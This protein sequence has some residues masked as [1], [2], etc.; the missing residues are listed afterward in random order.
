[1][2]HK[3]GVHLANGPADHRTHIRLVGDGC[4]T[5]LHTEAHLLPT[6]RELAPNSLI[7]IRHYL[8][9]WYTTDIPQYARECAERYIQHKRFTKHLTWANEQNLADESAGVIGAKPDRRITRT[10]YITIHNWNNKFITAFLSHPG[11]EDAILHYP[12]F[13]PG[14]SD[15]NDD[16]GFV[17]LEIC[18]PSIERCAILDRH[19]YPRLDSFVSNEWHGAGRL[20]HT[21]TKFPSKPIFISECGNFTVTDPRSPEHYISMGKFWEQ[22]P[23]VLGWTY[24]I[25]D[26]PTGAHTYNNM[27]LNSR[28]L[29]EVNTVS[30]VWIEDGI[31]NPTPKSSKPEDTDV[32]VGPG[33]QKTLN[34]IGYFT[35]DEVYHWWGSDHEVS[36]AVGERGYATWSKT[37]NQVTV[38]LWDGSIYTDGGNVPLSG[39]RL[40]KVK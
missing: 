27:S 33:F 23:N 6:I 30:K 24:F 22:H 36:L 11:T 29:D 1:M 21:T 4:F 38:V 13:A 40:V 16:Y 17:G 20:V 26:D 39:G 35:E 31:I 28:I 3:W 7:L 9:D 8:P 37:S 19:F 2:R 5:I 14:H 15:D 10:D 12:A 32:K 34:L 18:R 25:A